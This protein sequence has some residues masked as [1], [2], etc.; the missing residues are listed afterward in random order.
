[1]V[2]GD[3]EFALMPRALAL[4]LTNRDENV[5][6]F[7]N[8]E[9]TGSDLRPL[10]GLVAPRLAH[11][12]PG[13]RHVG[14][15]RP[16]T[17]V[18]VVFDAEY[19]VATDAEREERR[20]TWVDR[21]LRALPKE[22]QTDI[23]A[24]QLDRVVVATTWN[25][26]GENFEFAH[27]TPLQLANAIVAMP[28]HRRPPDLEEKRKLMVKARDEHINLKTMVPGG[29]KTRLA[30]EVWP[31]LE[32]RIVNAMAKNTEKRIPIVRVLDEAIALAYEFPRRGLVLRIDPPGSG[33]SA[34]CA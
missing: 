19:P 20:Q 3:T 5:I 14:L 16:M 26:K 27:F 4:L 32:R 31:L 10:T 6:T 33:T 23:V 24:K 13:A 12:D 21:M 29:S 22:H 2:E 15:L 9:G 7:F 28:G 30:E 11:A 1:V 17:R 25:R 34:T 8:A 18:L